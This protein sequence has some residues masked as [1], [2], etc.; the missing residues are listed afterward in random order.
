MTPFRQ[1]TS[2]FVDGP[3]QEPAPL[4]YLTPPSRA[5]LSIDLE[6][7]LRPAGDS[8]FHRITHVD[9]AEGLYWSPAQQLAHMTVNGA[10]LRPGDLFGSGT[11]SGP[12]KDTRGCFLE[13]TWSGHD[14]LTRADGSSRTFLE[15]GDTVVL[16]ASAPG[17]DGTVVGFCEC[18][19]T[20]R[21]ATC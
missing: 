21:P 13:L 12:E 15:D 16:R 19:G 14:P 3:E 6:V 1:L 7:W 20:V 4:P 11:V 17:P 8:R 10:T 9:S 2:A 18:V 5:Q